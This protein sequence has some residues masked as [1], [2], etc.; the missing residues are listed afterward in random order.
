MELQN[1]LELHN[2]EKCKLT[3]RTW[4]PLMSYDTK[5]NVKMPGNL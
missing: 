5:S 1:W 3:T 2:V 4:I